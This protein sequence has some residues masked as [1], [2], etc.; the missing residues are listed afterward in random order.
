MKIAYLSNENPKD[1]NVWSGTPSY[2]YKTL[3]IHHEITWIGRGVLQGARWHHIFLGK[4]DIFFPHDYCDEICKILS[5]TIRKG[6]FDIVISSNYL[7]CCNLDINIPIIF[8]NDVVYGIC[9]G[10][11][12]EPNADF[13]KRAIN[14]EGA[15]LR[16]VDKIIYSSEFARERAISDYSLHKDKIHVLEFGANIPE[17]N[18]IVVTEYDTN[19]C[20]LVFVG[21]NW[22]KKGGPKVL[23][24]YRILKEQGFK[25]HLTIIG[26]KPGDEDLLN[27][28]I[29]II[30]W[31]DKSCSK[32]IETYFKILRKSHFMILPTKF[33]AFGIVFCEASAFGV[34]SI[35]TNIGGVNQ[36]I[37]DGINGFLLPPEATAQDYANKIRKTFESK[38]DYNILRINSRIEY[39]SRL[40]WQ[41]WG[42][43]VNSIINNLVESNKQQKLEKENVSNYF[44]PV[45]VFNLKTRKDRLKHIRLQFKNRQEFNVTYMD[46]VY[47][48]IGAVGLW[49][50]IC[51]AVRLA[52]E[53]D[54]DI[55]ILCEDDHEF[56]DNYNFEY[57]LN[58]IATAYTQGTEL[59][60]GGIAGFG[61]AIP[62]AKNR[63]HVD[64]FWGTQFIVIYKQLFN[65]ILEYEFKDTDTADGVLSVLANNVQIM[66]PPIST[67][68]DF[69]YSDI[70]IQKDISTF[71]NNIFTIANQRLH[72]VYKQYSEFIFNIQQNCSTSKANV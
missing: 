50:S 8:V 15:C 1:V 55:I 13:R 41:V 63:I 18:N 72:K 23:S 67:Q 61:N 24:A 14:R 66:Y 29:C 56:T 45:Y 60:N 40:N 62:I 7:L 34:P 2:I 47:H 69:G 54:E 35:A 49:K 65:K 10:V 57:L 12:F 44:I 26:C 31:L 16:N 30:P 37:K 25:C 4:S 33:D 38:D 42:K 27:E 59:L 53:R 5:N 68:T 36:V 21:R 71:Q 6:N 20:N 22:E 51:N 39:E 9:E 70:S 28:D 3:A 43:T 19:I 58:N 11:F 48:K 32:D 64:W 46:A 52:I 17:P